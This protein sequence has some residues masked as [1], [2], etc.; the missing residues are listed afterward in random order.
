[1]E[2]KKAKDELE[3]DGFITYNKALIIYEKN[4]LNPWAPV[5]GTKK[6]IMYNLIA[7]IVKLYEELYILINEIELL[8][9]QI[10]KQS[11]IVRISNMYNSI[12]ILLEKKDKKHYELCN[13]RNL[14]K[15]QQK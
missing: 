3:I 9:E 4:K 6:N 5:V 13:K 11:D 1:M 8:N 14:Y 12:D 7:Q 10:K 15:Q 2:I